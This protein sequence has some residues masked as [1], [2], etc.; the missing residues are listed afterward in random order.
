MRRDI[1]V[2]SKVTTRPLKKKKLE[3]KN[4]IDIHK[5]KS[6]SLPKILMIATYPPRECG[7]AT[8]T[9][10]LK[11]ALE[12]QFEDSFDI[13]IC[14][15]KSNSDTHDYKTEDVDLIL[16]PDSLQSFTSIANKINI[17]KDMEMVMIQHEFGLFHN[18][19]DVFLNFLK[20]LNKPIII[21]FHTVLPN[22]NKDLEKHV[23]DLVSI[24]KVVTVMTK[25]S[26][27]LLINT[28]AV[29]PSK[30]EIISHGTHLVKHQDKSLL[31]DKYH[32]S[33]RKVISTFGF[34]GPGKNIETTLNA[35]P[36][37]IKEHPEILFLIVGKTHPTLFNQQGDAYM[38]SLQ[39]KVD[40]LKLT[41]H[42]QFVNKFVPLAELL[43][44]LQLS[45]CYVF[46]SN[47]PNQAVSGTFSY[48]VSCGC[49]I[50][51]TPIPH[52][53]EVLRDGNGLLFDFGDSKQLADK[54]NGLL[55]NDDLRQHMKM[56]GLHASSTTSWENA[57]ISH[58]L[59]F[60]KQI[61]EP[62]KLNYKKPPINIHHLLNMT[63]D[64]GMIQ[65]SN[66]NTPDMESGYTLDDNARALIAACEYYKLSQNPTDIKLIRKYVNFILKCQR[67]NCLFLNYVDKDKRFTNQNNEV[68]LEDS[69]GRAIWALGYTYCLMEEGI[70]L[71]ITLLQ[72][73]KCTINQF[74]LKIQHF[75]SP[76][77]LA[78]AMKGLYYFNLKMDDKKITEIINNAANKLVEL[79]DFHSEK[80]WNWFEPYLTYA[81]SVLPESLL[82]AWKSTGD[83]RFK[84]IAKKS[85]DFL[86]SK[87][88]TEDSIRVISNQS[89]LIKGF[90]EKTVQTG[91]EQPIDVA[92][93]ILALKEFNNIFPF[94]DYDDKMEIAFSWFLG[95]NQLK[96]I[97]YN[98]C[99]GGCHDGL[100]EHNVNL[101][102]GAESTVSYLLARFAF[103]NI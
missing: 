16:N 45:D 68:N 82:Y 40:E 78:F 17:D 79:Y 95:N 28:Y 48:A 86:I 65:F 53:K 12:N 25:S 33:N 10:D 7:I 93:T 9:F 2:K 62:L 85:F 13:K 77:A 54:V 34:L 37:I 81:N 97:I 11:K 61:D 98:P 59:V 51:S 41:K 15:L 66:I 100:E 19:E 1:D 52:A 69:N 60:S 56:K 5:M 87:I 71:D 49:P 101:N 73:I 55:N 3:L 99:T 26:A 42:V 21:A 50:V 72:N 43:E 80:D 38:H 102:Q 39:K 8:Y 84:R 57:A 36:A 18:N 29:N 30:I 58:A 24:A 88:F 76:R 83:I 70:D 47:D 91:G 90:E 27:D 75:K 23:K 92:Y 46:T 94:E 31:K 67:D 44:Y 74:N 63:T 96:Q 14:A 103:E 6:K 64:I 89:W 4:S 35:L 32:V 22:P 20:A